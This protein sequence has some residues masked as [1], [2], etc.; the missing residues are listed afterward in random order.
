MTV[1]R[2]LAALLLLLFHCSCD[3]APAAETAPAPAPE[4]TPDMASLSQHVA[5]PEWFQDAKLGIYFHWGVYTV[6]AFDS[7]WYPYNM[8]Q[9]G[10]RV[11]EHH[12]AKYGDVTEFGYHDFVPLF[13]ADKFDPEAMAE[14]LQYAGARFS[15]PVSQH[16]DG[17]A[18]WDS[19]VN[20]WNAADKGPKRDL[21]G[22][23]AAALRKRDMKLIATFHHAR[24][25][26]RNQN[27]TYDTFDSHFA[28]REDW[29]TATEDPE[30]RK[31]YGNLPADEFHDYWLDQLEEVIDQYDP[32]IVWFD[33]WL[34]LIPRD[35]RNRFMAYYLNHA[36]QTGQEVVMV[37][38]QS[39]LPR[40]I[41]VQDIEQGGRQDV[42][43][44]PW[45][46]DVTLSNE[47]WSYV[48]GQTY[49]SPALVVRNM[50]DVVSKN[51]VV[52]LNCSPRADGSLPQEQIDL[53]RAIGDWMQD[54]GEAFFN[55]RPWDLYGLGTATAEAGHFGGQSATVE[56]TARDV[57]FTQSKDQR[58]LY[59]HFL[60]QP[61]GGTIE[62]PLMSAH[63]Y[64]PHG[65]IER[66][67]LLGD[68]REL[69]FEMTDTNFT[70]EFPAG[71]GND[72]AT[73]LKVEL[74]PEGW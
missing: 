23:Y 64:E 55:T 57:R 17:F 49:K 24:N 38:K 46:T 12:R 13:T 62:L 27:D 63:R 15:G 2:P 34:N 25:L 32:D 50:I 65:E 47:S 72:V 60:G 21:L 41:A 19:D 4:Y 3:P 30:L 69:D 59:I 6:P 11:F 10:S 28:W 56:Y 31:L 74:D 61:A 58:T 70:I 66:I 53:L 71:A 26:Q 40:E 16:H 43:E 8:F 36:R 33:S 68:G 9:E 7:E 35:Y 29:P 42:T 52:L 1:R 37:Y 45:M 54:H 14:L 73:V 44:K 51:G 5:A 67:T 22:E 20:P 39:D 48:E 18:L